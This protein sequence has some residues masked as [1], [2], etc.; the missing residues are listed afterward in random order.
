M[1]YVCFRPEED[2]MVNEQTGKAWVSRLRGHEIDDDILPHGGIV[3]NTMELSEPNYISYKD[4]PVAGIAAGTTAVQTVISHQ[5]HKVLDTRLGADGKS[6]VY[7]CEGDEDYARYLCA[8]RAGWRYLIFN[9]EDQVPRKSQQAASV[10][11]TEAALPT[12]ISH[13][14]IAKAG[15]TPERIALKAEVRAI[16]DAGG[17][18]IKLSVHDDLLRAY[19]AENR[20]E[21]GDGADQGAEGQ[22]VGSVS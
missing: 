16:R 7:I 9:R 3:L 2:A 1:I 8:I 18:K 21:T 11:D 10:Q 17:P 22:A 19:I 15:E 5:T 6:T 4:T 14:P 13:A 12:P 20:G